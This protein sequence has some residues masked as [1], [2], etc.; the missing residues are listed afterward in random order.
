VQL[1]QAVDLLDDGESPIAC[2]HL[3]S[4]GQLVAGRD[5]EV[6]RVPA[7]GPILVRGEHE[8]ARAIASTAFAQDSPITQTTTFVERD[9]VVVDGAEERAVRRTVLGRRSKRNVHGDPSHSGGGIVGRGLEPTVA[10]AT[11]LRADLRGAIFSAPRSAL[12]ALFVY[13]AANRP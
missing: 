4:P 10:P 1:S 11:L 8:R 5:N 2:D 7:N 13:G 12:Q 3:L 6:P 9:D